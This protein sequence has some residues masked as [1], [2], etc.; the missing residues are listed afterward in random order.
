MRLLYALL[1]LLCMIV[2]ALAG[3]PDMSTCPEWCSQKRNS[4]GCMV[5]ECTQ[6]G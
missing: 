1:L 6:N 5:C 4:D 3:C 2:Y